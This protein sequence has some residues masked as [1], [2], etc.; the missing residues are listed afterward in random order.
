MIDILDIIH[1]PIFILNNISETGL[2]L[3]LEDILQS[4]NVV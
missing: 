3:H 4:I 2:C 1:H